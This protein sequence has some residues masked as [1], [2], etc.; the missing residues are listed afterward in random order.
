MTRRGAVKRIDGGG[1]GKK[2]K[3]HVYKIIEMSEIVIRNGG[4]HASWESFSPER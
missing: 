2:S 1:Y 4:E 3:N